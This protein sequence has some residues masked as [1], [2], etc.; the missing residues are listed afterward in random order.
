[1]FETVYSAE[2][3]LRRPRRFLRLALADLARSRPA[4]WALFLANLRAQH[5]RAWLGYLW[6][7]LPALAAA[8]VGVFVQSRGIVAVA[9]TRLSYPLFAL[10]GLILCQS[11]L[12]ALNAPLEQ[13][14]G[15]RQMITRSTVPH[16]A[17]IGAAMLRICLNA[18]VRLAV[19]AAAFAVAGV[20]VAPTALLVPFGLAALILLGLSLGL[21]T[22]PLGLVSDDVPRA[23]FL[24]STF[25]FF[26]TPVVYPVP[27]LPLLRLNPVAILIDTTRAWLSGPAPSAALLAIAVGALT[28]LVAAWL[29]DRL[30]RPHV[31]A[32][33]G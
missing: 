24:A 9:A 23:I 18:L 19:L 30:A 13:L 22:A 21:L 6:L 20:P 12:D 32:R 33:L 10:T 27:H 11:I 26:L 14:G 1:M 2:P 5:R 31:V 8:G 3:E 29:L 4:A 28:L 17:V 7:L 16:E 15:A 25:L